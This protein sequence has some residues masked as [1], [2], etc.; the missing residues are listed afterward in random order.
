MKIITIHIPDHFLKIL[1]S[2]VEEGLFPNRSEAI[3]VGIKELLEMEYQMM[4]REKSLVFK[5]NMAQE[6]NKNPIT[7][8]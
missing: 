1:D 6:R 8:V 5:D 7:K 2:L 4:D 3:R